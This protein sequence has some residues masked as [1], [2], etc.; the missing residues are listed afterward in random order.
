MD[1]C[2]RARSTL[3][4]GQSRLAALREEIGGEREREKLRYCPW[5]GPALTYP[6]K[7][8]VLWIK[9]LCRGVSNILLEVV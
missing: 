3:S 8:G 5:A 2:N 1:V 7:W 6:T 4:L 9:Q